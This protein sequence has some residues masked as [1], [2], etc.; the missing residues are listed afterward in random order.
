MYMSTA[1]WLLAPS[2]ISASA[3]ILAMTSYIV[4]SRLSAESGINFSAGAR[5]RKRC[6]LA[7]TMLATAECSSALREDIDFGKMNSAT[8]AS[9]TFS[10]DRDAGDGPRAS[11]SFATAAVSFSMWVIAFG[12][13]VDW[14]C[15]VNSPSIFLSNA[16]MPHC[17]SRISFATLA[18]SLNHSRSAWSDCDRLPASSSSTNVSRF[19]TA[20]QPFGRL[21]TSSASPARRFSSSQYG[22]LCLRCLKR[23]SCARSAFASTPSVTPSFLL[24]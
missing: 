19:L 6:F 4:G 7:S 3:S 20:T 11:I 24:A 23:G 15:L 16:S 14:K 21:I 2:T 13:H 1:F 5:S 18:S 17:S 22:V 10:S 12:T 8:K 9:R